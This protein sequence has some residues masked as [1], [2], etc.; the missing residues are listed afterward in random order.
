M[1][2]EPVAETLDDIPAQAVDRYPPAWQIIRP[3]I[4]NNFGK[5]FVVGID[6]TYIRVLEVDNVDLASCLEVLDFRWDLVFWS[7]RVDSGFCTWLPCRIFWVRF[8]V[9]GNGV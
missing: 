9:S 1:E 7:R 8:V 6:M 3:W 4:L 5:G 2:M